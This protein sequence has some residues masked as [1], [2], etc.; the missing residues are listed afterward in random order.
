MTEKDFILIADAL[1]CAKPKYAYHEPGTARTTNVRVYDQWCRSVGAI[2]K[3]LQ[4]EYPN[5]DF[6]KF[7]EY[8]AS[9]TPL[10]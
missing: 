4:K 5:F 3:Q 8:T 1:N 10:D 9:Y 2:A 7:M 6:R